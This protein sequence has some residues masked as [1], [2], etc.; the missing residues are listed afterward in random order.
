MKEATATVRP[1]EG[2]VAVVTGASQGLGEVARAGASL[3]S[4]ES[5][6][7]TGSNIDFDQTIL[8]AHD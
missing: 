3:A 7:T 2:R 1:L 4:E 5:G 6:P 8:G